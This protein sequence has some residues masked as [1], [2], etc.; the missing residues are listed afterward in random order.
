MQC[1]LPYANMAFCGAVEF[2]ELNLGFSHIKFV[3]L[4]NGLIHN[5]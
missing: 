4:Q 2:F 3:I 5:R 1:F